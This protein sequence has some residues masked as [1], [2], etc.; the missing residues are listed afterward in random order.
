MQKFAIAACAIALMGVPAIADEATEHQFPL[1]MTEFMAAYPDATPEV[2]DQVDA[3][4]DGEISEEE[5][6]D[7]REAGLIGD[8]A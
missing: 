6:R 8:D 7:A 4:G 1:T 3:D 2:F 5:Y